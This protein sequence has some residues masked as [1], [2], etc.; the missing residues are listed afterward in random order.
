[1]K[2]LEQ[3]R[4]RWDHYARTQHRFARPLNVAKALA[5]LREGFPDRWLQGQL[6][7]RRLLCLAAGGGK[8]AVLYALA[9]AEV[10]VVDLSPEML[11]LD[12]LMAQ[13]AGVQV[14]TVQSTMEDLSMFPPQSF[15]IVVQPV[16]TCYVP[17]VGRVYREVARVLVPGGLYISQ[18]KQPLALQARS[19][20][21]PEGYTV[22]LP[23]YHHGPLPPDE[24]G[25]HREAGTV[26]YLH[27]L[28][29]LL[30]GLCRA[31]FVIEDLE[32]PRLGRPDASPGSFA[33]RSWFLPPF[34][35]IKARRQGKDQSTHSPLAGKLQL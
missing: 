16:S 32:E 24:P 5:K 11:R 20:P 14:R 33:H 31:G 17:D 23:Y 34:V 35:R 8:H 1:M 28:E 22:A 29:E 6:S 25:L 2:H 15:D 27:R 19:R 21:G 13:Q 12:R 30:G 3:N 10:T 7:Q 26:E 9:G 4:R 18:H